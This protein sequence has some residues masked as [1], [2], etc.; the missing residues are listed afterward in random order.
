MFLATNHLEITLIKPL[1]TDFTLSF[2]S[3]KFSHILLQK[4]FSRNQA[5]YCQFKKLTQPYIS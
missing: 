1:F 2:P 4:V 3:V 5:V